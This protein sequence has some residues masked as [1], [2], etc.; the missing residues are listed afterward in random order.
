MFTYQNISSG[1]S[2]RASELHNLRVLASLTVSAVASIS[3]TG[4][5]IRCSESGWLCPYI[6]AAVALVSIPCRQVGI[7]AQIS[8]LDDTDDYFSPLVAHGIPSR[9]MNTSQ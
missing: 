5:G 7:V 6:H 8:Q 3:W 9:T 1:F 2:L 4:P